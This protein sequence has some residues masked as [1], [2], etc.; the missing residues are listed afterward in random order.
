[1][2]ETDLRKRLEAAAKKAKKSGVL[3]Y[4]DL[5]E[6]LEDPQKAKPKTPVKPKA[7]PKT[8]VKPKATPKK[9]EETR[10][11]K[12]KGGRVKRK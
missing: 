8:P 10:V 3:Q 4:G 12:K 9:K 1:M 11:P 5:Q 2:S 7:K 6:L